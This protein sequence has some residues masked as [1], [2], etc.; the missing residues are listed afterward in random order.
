MQKRH[1]QRSGIRDQGSGIRER[2]S[3]VETD[4]EP[5]SK[6]HLPEHV[7]V[8]GNQAGA[9]T[10]GERLAVRVDEGAEQARLE[11]QGEVAGWY[12]LDAAAG[13]EAEPYLVVARRAVAREAEAA[14]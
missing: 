4:D 9:W 13:G 3:S 5:G 14:S 1:Y 2:S 11:A 8:E 7:R 6:F 10:A 12:E